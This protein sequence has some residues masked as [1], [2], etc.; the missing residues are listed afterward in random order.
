MLEHIFPL[1]SREGKKLFEL[2]SAKQQLWLYSVDLRTE[3]VDRS[4]DVAET[5]Q[6]NLFNCAK[7]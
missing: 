1:L 3:H 5:N 2:V 6:T 4:K 7:R